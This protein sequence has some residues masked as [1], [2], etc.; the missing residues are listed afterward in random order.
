MIKMSETEKSRASYHDIYDE[1]RQ[2]GFY[3]SPCASCTSFPHDTDIFAT[4]K[5]KLSD[6]EIAAD[7]AFFSNNREKFVCEKRDVVC[8]PLKKDRL[9]GE[10]RIAI[11]KPVR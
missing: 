5:D 1:L 8:M 4:T 10:L 9:P 11:G 6:P 7:F 2:N 3:G